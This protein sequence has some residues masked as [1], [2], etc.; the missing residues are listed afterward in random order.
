MHNQP[1][2]SQVRW[3]A[4]YALQLI[5]AAAISQQSALLAAIQDPQPM[6][7]RA[8]ADALDQIWQAHVHQGSSEVHPRYRHRDRLKCRCWQPPVAVEAGAILHQALSD[9]HQA[10]IVQIASI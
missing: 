1:A 8:A 9:D 4:S 7:R 10:P 5:G 6:V 2:S 3:A